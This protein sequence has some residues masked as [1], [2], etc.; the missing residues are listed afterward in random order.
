[1]TH[2]IEIN[3]LHKSYGRNEAILRGLTV[4]VPRGAVYGLLGRNGS[5]KTTCLRTL[6]GLLPADS[7][8]ARVLGADMWLAARGE[9]AR[10]AYVSQDLRLFPELTL[11][12]HLDYVEALYGRFDRPLSVELM[13]RFGLGSAGYISALSGGQQ[14]MAAILM[15]LCSPAEVL[16]FDEPTAGL[17]P[18]ARRRFLEACS[19]RLADQPQTTILLSTHLMSDLE[20]LATHVGFLENGVIDR[21]EDLVELQEYAQ[22]FQIIF[23]PEGPPTDLVIPPSVAP[24]LEGQVLQFIGG[25][26]TASFVRSAQEHPAVR[27]Q[28]FP[29]NLEDFF[30][31]W[32]NT[33]DAGEGA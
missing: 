12:E 16:L 28:E 11:A 20:R 4:S 9:R 29:L 6:M 18:S 25:K 24:K 15:A 8:Q 19:A 2:A 26:D 30:V 31:D 33:L 13:E 27:V 7:G 1:M 22:R 3:N 32:A 14:R 21:S 10:V 17:D 23:P 5:G